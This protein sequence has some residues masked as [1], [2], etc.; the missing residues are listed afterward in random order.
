MPG[1]ATAWSSRL[2]PSPTRPSP[3]TGRAHE[4]SPRTFRWPYLL[5]ALI[6]ERSAADSLPLYR[7][8]LAIDPDYAPARTSA[9]RKRWNERASSTPPIASTRGRP[10]STRPTPTLTQGWAA[11]HSS[12]A[13]R[14]PPFA[15]CPGPGNSRPRTAPS[16]SPWPRRTPGPATANG[17][18]GSPPPRARWTAS[19]TATIRSVR[20]STTWR[21]TPAAT[22]DAP[23]PTA[24]T[25]NSTSPERELRAGIELDGERP[26]LHFALAE[27][28]AA[29]DDPAGSLAA[30][31]R[32]YELHPELEGVVHPFWRRALFQ[33]GDLNG[34]ALAMA[35]AALR[36]RRRRRQH[37]APRRL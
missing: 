7:A 22:C 16:R 36:T 19:T 14:T 25:A 34:S 8:A 15:I 21:S 20:A 27:V 17:D 29:S 6:D 32:A 31:R 33:T 12:P 24:F 3:P 18:N 26:E 10:A 4:L 30:A 5:A 9:W 35:E 28:L 1:A 23:T 2:T 37:D 13:M 11:S